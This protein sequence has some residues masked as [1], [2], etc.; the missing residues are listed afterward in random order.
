MAAPLQPGEQHEARQRHR[1]ADCEEQRP[2]GRVRN[3]A[4]DGRQIRAPDR[5]ERGEQRVL[6]GG[7]QRVAA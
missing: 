6:G 3:I 4:G 5:G 2:A 1:D 7:V